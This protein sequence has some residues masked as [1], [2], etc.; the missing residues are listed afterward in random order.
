MHLLSLLNVIGGG[1]ERLELEGARRPPQHHDPHDEAEV[2]ELRDPEG[3]DRRARGRRPLVPVADQ[4]IRAE[5]D[6]LPEDEHLDERGRQHEPEHREGEERL[7]GVVA[8]QGGRPLVSEVRQRVDL[9]EQGHERD[10]HEHRARQRVHEEA[11]RRHRATVGR[12]PRPG[13]GAPGAVA[14]DSQRRDVG[15]GRRQDRDGARRASRAAQ[16]RHDGQDEESGEG[17][18]EDQERRAHA[19]I[20]RLSPGA[21]RVGLPRRSAGR[22]R[23]RSRSRGPRPPRRR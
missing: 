20:H 8:A 18:P 10:E 21:G 1:E 7:V 9:D 13:R 16:R 11:D 4:E 2:A 12:D 5:P 15:H 6:Q 19:E 22:G 14:P 3:L 17:Q 23:S